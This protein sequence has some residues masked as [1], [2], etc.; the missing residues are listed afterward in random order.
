MEID[1]PSMVFLGK[2][3]GSKTFNSNLGKFSYLL[4]KQ[5]L[6]ARVVVQ[7]S[8]NYLHFSL[9]KSL[10]KKE[11]NFCYSRAWW[12]FQGFHELAH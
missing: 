10:C 6:L 7:N 5:N 1:L 11:H 2:N 3:S 8:N 9:V 4:R 12:D